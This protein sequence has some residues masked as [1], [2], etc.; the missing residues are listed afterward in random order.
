[1]NDHFAQNFTWGVLLKYGKTVGRA[2]PRHKP[3]SMK[4][5]L[6]DRKGSQPN[7]PLPRASVNI[8][9]PSPP[10]LNGQEMRK[11]RRNVQAM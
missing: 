4:I 2:V 6:P 11:R 7:E 10:S 9:T 3:G 1:M 8:P 5:A